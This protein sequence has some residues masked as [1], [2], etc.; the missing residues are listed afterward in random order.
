MWEMKDPMYKEYLFNFG[1]FQLFTSINATMTNFFMHIHAD[2]LSMGCQ[3]SKTDHCRAF[4]IDCWTMPFELC[5][6]SFDLLLFDWPLL[7]DA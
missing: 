2:A 1:N 5:F 6:M 3:A 4:T 7:I